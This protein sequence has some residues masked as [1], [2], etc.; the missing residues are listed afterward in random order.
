M[1]LDPKNFSTPNFNEFSP[2]SSIKI[3]AQTGASAKNPRKL[4]STFITKPVKIKITRP[5]HPTIKETYL[6]K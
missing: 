4:D 6:G 2:A 1:S 3:A 5:N